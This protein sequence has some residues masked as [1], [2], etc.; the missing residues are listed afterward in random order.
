MTRRNK[1]RRAA[2]IA[3]AAAA[4]GGL[5][6]T[7]VASASTVQRAAPSQGPVIGYGATGQG[8]KCVQDAMD[9]A[10]ENG[11]IDTNPSVDGIYGLTT[12]KAVEQFQAAVELKVDGIVGVR[13]GDAMIANMSAAGIDGWVDDCKPYIPNNLIPV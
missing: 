2:G 13:T 9:W 8:V 11:L 12:K 7:G 5:G 4:I 1:L 3:A 6:V 10:W